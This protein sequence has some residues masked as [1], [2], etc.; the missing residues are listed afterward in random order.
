[1]CTWKRELEGPA[2]GGGRLVV[3]VLIGREERLSSVSLCRL[4][5]GSCSV[6]CVKSCLVAF[7]DWDISALYTSSLSHSSGIATELLE[8]S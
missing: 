4:G 5:G 1:M 6:G 2:A 7:E 3:G 8:L